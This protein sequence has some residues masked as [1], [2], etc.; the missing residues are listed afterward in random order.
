MVEAPREIITASTETAPAG[1]IVDDLARG[2][3]FWEAFADEEEASEARAGVVQASKG[4]AGRGSTYNSDG[5][6][7]MTTEA[8]IEALPRIS[9]NVDS[10][11]SYTPAS[12][13]GAVQDIPAAV[14]VG[15]AP[16]GNAFQV[17]WLSTT[18]VPFYKTRGIRNPL[19]G[20]REV[21]I[22][23]DGTRIALD[24]GVKL[25]ELFG[26]ARKMDQ[27]AEVDSLN[28]SQLEIADEEQNP[29]EASQDNVLSAENTD[30]G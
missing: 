22:A 18:R 13:T 8:K 2:T 28:V 17:E 20:N 6:Q 27:V 30:A 14:V 16:S 24:V 5:V 29:E 15:T 23:R 10:T 11:G 26:V 19:N 9:I 4:D 7:S 12:K 1:R 21:K 3:I 25:M